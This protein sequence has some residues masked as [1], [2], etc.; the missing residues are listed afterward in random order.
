[1]ALG[2][3]GTEHRKNGSLLLISFAVRFDNFFHF[4]TVGGRLFSLFTSATNILP[5]TKRNSVTHPLLFIIVYV[6]ATNTL[7]IVDLNS[8]SKTGD[9]VLYSAAFR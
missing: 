2:L 1:M 8:N 6:L 5:W 3:V 4:I 9:Y 7:L